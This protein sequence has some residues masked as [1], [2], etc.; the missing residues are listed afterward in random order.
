MC[1]RKCLAS[2]R[3]KKLFDSFEEVT[4]L[5]KTHPFILQAVLHLS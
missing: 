4:M 1:L 3:S 2:N 5:A